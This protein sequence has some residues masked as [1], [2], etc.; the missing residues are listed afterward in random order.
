[1]AQQYIVQ[2][3]RGTKKE[4]EDYENMPS[5]IKPLAG[6]L[7]IEF[8]DINGKKIPRLKIGTGDLE[9]SDLEYMSVDSFIL[10]KPISVTLYADKWEQATDIDG[11]DVVNTY[12][13]VVTVENAIITPRSKVDL[14]PT[15]N[16]LCRLY[17]LGVALT[18]KNAG[19]I[20]TV[21]AVGAKPNSSLSIQAT[22]T[23]VVLD[24]EVI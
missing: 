15:T 22:V 16:D 6:E 9:F 11:A 7:V 8:D 21:Y 1:M 5:H 24:G 23:E 17:D 12:Y 4:W 2:L 3:R 13:Q 20:I 19:G 18:T 10:P 14:Q